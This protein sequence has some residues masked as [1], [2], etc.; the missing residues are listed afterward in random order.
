MDDRLIH[1]TKTSKDFPGTVILLIIIGFLALGVILGYT[2]FP[3]PQTAEQDLAL[4]IVIP[5]S[6][7]TDSSVPADTT[8]SS[9]V[10]TVLPQDLSI[11]IKQ[12]I[13]LDTPTGY[14]NVRLGA[15]TNFQKIGQIKP[16]EVYELISEDQANGGW[17]QVK[18]ASDQ[19]G[20]VSR[21]YVQ[22]K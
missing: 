12:I 3:S 11:P 20:W 8:A 14:L 4:E 10:D 19:T 13:V 9:S 1:K 21:K 6:N 18:L 17:Y 2:Y 15:G 22:I 7:D 16:G 5:E